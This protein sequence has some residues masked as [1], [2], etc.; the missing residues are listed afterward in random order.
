MSTDS[1]ITLARLAELADDA[2]QAFG[3]ALGRIR[4]AAAGA[5]ALAACVEEDAVTAAFALRALDEV[6]RLNVAAAATRLAELALGM[7]P[8]DG[9]PAPVVP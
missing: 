4:V 5:A 8:A 9:G 2:A 3:G 6:G 7:P 1:A